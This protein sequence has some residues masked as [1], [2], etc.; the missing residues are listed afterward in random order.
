MI[1]EAQKADE[2]ALS[3]YLAKHFATSMFMRGNLR[4]FG[5]ANTEAPYAMRYFIRY[6][7]EHITGVGA[8]ANIG[9]VM[10][11]ADENRAEIV[12]HIARVLPKNF[13]PHAITGAPEQ[14]LALVKGLG[15]GALPTKMNDIEPLFVLK[16]AGLRVPEMDGFSLRASSMEDL[17]LLSAWNHS[18]NMEVLGESDTEATRQEIH[19]NAIRTI[20]RGHQRVLIKNGEIVAQ[21]NFNAVM[22]DAVQVGGVYT[23]PAKRGQ[24]FARRAVG[25]HLAEAFA[26]SVQNAILFSASDAASKAYRA[27]GFERIGEYQII[28]F[29]ESA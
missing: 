7:G 10:L 27:V 1:V 23:P 5:L 8:L 21:T 16:E 29:G 15:F 2:P 9:A 20:E 14:V 6:A 13:A 26:G 28:L 24:G 11:Q 17:P 4:D 25:A 18:Y 19:A 12:E 22:P 3:A